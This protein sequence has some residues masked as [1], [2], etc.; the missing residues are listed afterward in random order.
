MPHEGCDHN[1]EGGP[2]ENGKAFQYV[3][4]VAVWWGWC[5]GVVDRSC[6]GR[7]SRGEFIMESFICRQQKTISAVLR[8]AA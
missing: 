5:L 7:G 2:Q 4:C 1:V 3:C 6:A 8:R